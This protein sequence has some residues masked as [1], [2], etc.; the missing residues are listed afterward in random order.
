MAGVSHCLSRPR[1][2]F[3]CQCFRESGPS[4]FQPETDSEPCRTRR[5]SNPSRQISPRTQVNEKRRKRRLNCNTHWPKTK[6]L[7]PGKRRSHLAV[8]P[9]PPTVPAPLFRQR[10]RCQLVFLSTGTSRATNRSSEISITSIGSLPNGR[11]C[12]TRRG[13]SAGYGRHIPGAELDSCHAT[14][15]PRSCRWCRTSSTRSGK[16]TCWRVR[17]PMSHTANI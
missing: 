3:Y 16:A 7:V 1:G 6:Y 17:S 15:S 9:P 8:V 5:I 13:E 14:G 10:A 11:I 2:R 12:K 4:E